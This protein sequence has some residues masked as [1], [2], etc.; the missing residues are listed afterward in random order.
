MHRSLIPFAVAA[1]LAAAAYG[2]TSDT[3]PA[4]AKTPEV[5]ETIQ[6]TATRI[7]E[8][9]LDVPASITV[10]P[11]DELAERGATDLAS[12]LA[13]AGGIS[14][15]PGGDGGPA[16]SVPELMGLKEFDAFLLVVD[17]VPWGGAFN[18][19]L[20]TLDLT[21]VDRIEILR[22]SAPVLYGATSFV[23]VIHVIHRRPEKTPRE[24]RIS[25]GSYGSGGGAVTSQL[26]GSETFHQALSAAFDRQGFKDDRTNFDRGHVL[27]SADGKT[28]GGS[29]QLGADFNGVRQEP[30]SPHPRTGRVL[31]DLIPID[32]NHNPS[33]ARIDENRL[34][35]RGTYEH[36][37]AAGAWT[38]TLNL[39]RTDRDTTRGF[40]REEFDVPPG[41]SN[42]D[43]F[44][45]N[46]KGDDLYFDTHVALKPVE[47]LSVVAGFDY[48]YGKGDAESNNFEYHV[49]LDGSNAPSSGPIHIDE[50][51]RFVDTRNFAGLYVQTLWTPAPRWKIDAGLRL[52]D[53]EEKQEGEVDTEDG[54]ERTTDKRTFTRLSGSAGASFLAWGSGTDAVWLYANYT[55]AFK[56]AAV[57][58]GPE[59][60][61][62][63]LDP[64][65]A[66]TVEVG[67][68]G[69]HRDGV[70]TWQASVFQMDFD[71]LVVPVTVNG[72]PS[73]ENAGQERFEG[74]ELEGRWRIAEDLTLEGS[75][76]DHSAKFRDY[77]RDFDGV[78]TQLRGNRLEMSPEQLAALG[79]TY[80]PRRGFIG[81]GLVNFVGDRYLD[82][83]N[84]ALAGSYTTCAAGFGYRFERGEARIDGT[85][86]SDERPPIAESELGDA[87]YYLLPARAVKATLTWRF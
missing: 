21:N 66:Q 63:I 28:A 14:I 86:L 44:R 37:I 19:A 62:E 78:P 57:D 26:P 7:P 5:S 84:R 56:P 32:S 23:G 18:P 61:G 69:S 46:F 24:A 76:A 27:W 82:K 15:A 10:I 4:T 25:A 38:T 65:T 77:V 52:N 42:A 22:G 29:Y 83:R 55:D 80:A 75:Y 72:L 6:V 64:E 8:E 67:V 81:Y 43:G 48:L 35:L 59:A 51:P 36:P 40:L 34:D 54:V 2:Q 39:T 20:S 33:D 87:Q 68:K 79:L 73:I 31:T 74:F 45:Q 3:P 70:L 58:F 47:S 17:G 30:A 11:G 53:T 12:A 71:N 1:G 49:A 60:E 13:L 9:I 16:S 41:V 85:N 50:R